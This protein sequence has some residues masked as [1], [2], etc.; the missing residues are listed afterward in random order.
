M[1][2]DKKPLSERQIYR[3]IGDIDDRFVDEALSYRAPKARQRSFRIGTLTAVAAAILLC[4]IVFSLLPDPNMGDA[5]G[6]E[7]PGTSVSWSVSE[8]YTANASLLSCLGELSATVPSSKTAPVLDGTVKIIWKDEA[9]GTYYEVALTEAT[10]GELSR[11][12]TL[13]KRDASA[14]SVSAGSEAPPYSVWIATSDGYAISPYL[15]FRDGTV[16]LGAPDDY[17]PE[18]LPTESFASF[19]EALLR[20][21]AD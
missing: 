15:P 1:N 18:I 17:A 19:I 11:L 10:Q 21:N 8:S 7:Q 5:P 16:F 4:A 6:G 14:A 12:S 20:K 9:T 3:A 2:H 13:M